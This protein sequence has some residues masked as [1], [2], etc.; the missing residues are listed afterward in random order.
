MVTLPVG[1]AAL[2][3]AVNVTVCPKTVGLTSTVSV[4]VLGS[5]PTANG[6]EETVPSASPAVALALSAMMSTSEY[7]TLSLHAVPP[8][9]ITQPR[10]PD[11][12]PV[13]LPRDNAIVVA[14]DTGC[15]FP[16]SSCASTKTSNGTNT[17]GCAPELI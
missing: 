5:C 1:A 16:S 11:R 6:E 13:P 3:V 2:T 17:K 14:L 9:G 12:A 8:A 15:G 7:V 4:V 10:L